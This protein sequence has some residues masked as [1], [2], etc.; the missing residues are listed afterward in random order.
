ME[1]L[2]KSTIVEF[3]GRRRFSVV[4]VDAEWDGYRKAL[5][6]RI[7]VVESQFEETV[8]FGYVDCDAEQDYATGI[9]L[10]SVPSVAYYAGARL[11]GVVIGTQQDVAGNIGRLMRGE[12]LDQQE[13][14]GPGSR[15][16]RTP[17]LKNAYS[18][19]AVVILVT[20]ASLGLALLVMYVI[21]K[22][23]G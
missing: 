3:L 11:Y 20:L 17:H 19:L 23:A 9:A 13:V 7:R 1:Q 8:S 16:A 14:L 10:L 2:S 18:P 5:A 22:I 15:K 21:L 4:H 6:E 12:P